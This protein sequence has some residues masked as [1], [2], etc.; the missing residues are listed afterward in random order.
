MKHIAPITEQQFRNL[1]TAPGSNMPVLVYFQAN[2]CG[3]CRMTDPILDELSQR[4]AGKLSV[5]SLDIDTC[6]DLVSEMKVHSIPT[7]HIYHY[8]LL[9][10]NKVGATTQEL[11]VDMIERAI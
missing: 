6:Q 8:G 4:Y 11:L 5:V 9:Q 2:W 10:A 7:M 1:A 3:P